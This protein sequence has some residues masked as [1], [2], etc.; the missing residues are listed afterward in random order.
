MS[1]QRSNRTYRPLSN[2]RKKTRKH[3][4]LWTLPLFFFVSYV[5]GE[6]VFRIDAG[7][8]FFGV[9][10]LFILLFGLAA[11]LLSSA[12]VCLCPPKWGRIVAIALVTV[13]LL[14]FG[15]QAVYQGVFGRFFVFSSIGGA[16]Q[17][18]E[19]WQ[20]TV[21][22][23]WNELFYILLY[24]LPVAFLLSPFHRLI[25]FPAF[26]W[27]RPAMLGAGGVVLHLFALLCLLFGGTGIGSVHEHFYDSTYS[28]DERV[29][30]LGMHQGFVRDM[31]YFVMGSG[32][33]ELEL[34]VEHE[35]EIETAGEGQLLF[36]AED[37]IIPG[38]A[39]DIST[40]TGDPS[41][42]IDRSPNVMEIDFD[43]LIATEKDDDVRAMHEYFSTQEP[44]LKNEH[45]GLFE[46]YNLIH[47]TAEGFSPYCI[48]PEYTPTLYKMVHDGYNFTNY[49]CP[50]WGVSTIDGEY[51]NNVGLLPK[52]GTWSYRDWGRNNG[53]LYFCFGNQFNRLGGYKVMA[54]HNHTYTYYTRN[55]Y[56][57]LSGYKEY[58]GYG[59]GLDVR[60]T[61]PESDLEM[62]QKSVPMFIDNDRFVID[63]MTVSG[64]LQYNFSGNFMAGKHKSV[65]AD[66]PYSEQI[67]A[68]LACNYDLELAMAY[69]LESLEAA[70]KAENTLIVLS[71]DHYPYGLY[72][73][74]YND[75]PTADY[76]S[77]FLGHKV[78]ENFELYESVLIV[79]AKGM[80]PETVDKP[81]YSIDILPTVSNLLGLEYDS[82]LLMGRDIFSDSEPLVIFL[83]RS[84]IT[85]KVRYNAKTKEVEFTSDDVVTEEYVERIKKIVKNKF[86]IS[87]NILDYDY[88]DKVFGN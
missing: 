58:Y 46:G 8:R 29:N 34:E 45:T 82:R 3:Q 48:D 78:E 63:Y 35:N 44:T 31:R 14:L 86:T 28:L 74:E 33:S 50:L 67:R 30:V 15:A 64:H 68:Y 24:A 6:L 43:S 13:S 59:N 77:D 39:E 20:V 53:N 62:M 88:Y 11:A 49:Y 19:F 56:L 72:K 81:C 42:I 18:A 36:N 54:F 21:K 73:C 16:G 52:S 26:Y 84:F 61:W 37:P 71:P 17:V 40:E 32:S 2:Q 80:T 12:L 65:Y 5:F 27:K 23:I 25:R 69:L 85:D 57:P 76:I 83:N 10:L 60:K 22:T 70:G 4:P 51:V 9:G 55:V 38:S 47:I 1:P 66:T 75:D 79:Y 7:I 87:T 41:V